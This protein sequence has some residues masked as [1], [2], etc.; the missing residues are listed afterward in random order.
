MNLE[1]IPEGI[2]EEMYDGVDEAEECF[3]REDEIMEMSNKIVHNDVEYRKSTLDN[4]D[5]NTKFSDE[6]FRELIYE[7]EVVA[8]EVAIRAE[9]ETKCLVVFDSDPSND[10]QGAVIK[11]KTSTHAQNDSSDLQLRVNLHN[12]DS[13]GSLDIS[14]EW[15]VERP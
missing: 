15:R 6:D 11:H 7:R 14:A 4:V 3:E 9:F 5:E 12:R 1:P 2:E 13:W 10:I 8:V